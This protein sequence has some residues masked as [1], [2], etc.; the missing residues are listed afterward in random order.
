[1]SMPT[2]RLTRATSDRER[3][4]LE[5]EEQKALSRKTPFQRPGR[6]KEQVADIE[7]FT[8]AAIEAKKRSAERREEQK[9]RMEILAASKRAREELARIIEEQKMIEE[10]RMI[11]KQRKAAELYAEQHRVPSP[12][13]DFPQEFYPTVKRESKTRTKT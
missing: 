5:R 11:E 7:E 4:A 12:V 3:R 9:K 1:M 13:Y 2:K 6:V 8:S 10:Q